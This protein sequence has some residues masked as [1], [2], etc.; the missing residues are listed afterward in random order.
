M[1]NTKKDSKQL[2]YCEETVWRYLHMKRLN[3]F[4]YL[5]CSGYYNWESQSGADDVLLYEKCTNGNNVKVD[6]LL[7]EKCTNGNNVK[8]DAEILRYVDCTNGSNVR[9]DT[10]QVIKYVNCTNGE[11]IMT[12]TTEL[13]SYDIL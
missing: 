7:Y 6:A 4:V 13:I 10:K 2:L 1:K 9:V 12:G 5:R 11:N 3:I 8:V